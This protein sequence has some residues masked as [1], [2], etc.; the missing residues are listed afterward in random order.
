MIEAA[1]RAV[2]ESPLAT[3]AV[4]LLLGGQGTETAVSLMRGDPVA[5]SPRIDEDVAALLD[6]AEDQTVL[7]R[8]LIREV[9]ATRPDL[10]D[11]DEV[12]E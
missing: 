7:L 6:E 12:A 1:K 8:R 4:V 11:D 2:S 5:Q 3:L 10:L 9:R